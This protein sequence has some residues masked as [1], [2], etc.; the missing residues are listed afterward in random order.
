MICKYV[1]QGKEPKYGE[2]LPIFLFENKRYL[3]VYF[4]ADAIILYIDL[5][6]EQNTIYRRGYHEYY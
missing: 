2:R 1:R 3:L 5:Y 4:K 6:K